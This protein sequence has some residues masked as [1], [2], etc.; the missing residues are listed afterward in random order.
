MQENYNVNGVL[1]N[2]GV[3]ML[4]DDED[5]RRYLREHMNK[6]RVLKLRGRG[7]PTGHNY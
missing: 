7:L 4:D 6:G 5:C 1:V 2:P 3:G